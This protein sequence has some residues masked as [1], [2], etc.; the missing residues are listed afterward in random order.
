M[1]DNRSSFIT[2]AAAPVKSLSS[3][4]Y[5][6]HRVLARF[7]S[8]TVSLSSRRRN[9]QCRPLIEALHLDTKVNPH[10]HDFPVKLVH[11]DKTSF[12]RVFL[13]RGKRI[14]ANQHPLA[15]GLVGEILIMRVSASDGT[16]LINA[17]PTDGPIMDHV[18]D[19][20]RARIQDFQEPQRNALPTLLTIQCLEPFPGPA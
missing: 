9:A 11:G 1:P 14:A 20:A 5:S 7:V 3:R 15:N 8:V 10:L 12:F 13:K 16:T 19:M 6:T 2:T 17:R 4:H 18:L